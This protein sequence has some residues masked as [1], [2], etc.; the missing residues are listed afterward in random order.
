M[1]KIIFI[2]FLFFGCATQYQGRGFSG[3]FS[4]LKLNNDLYQV[5]FNGNGYTSAARVQRYFLRRCAEIAL[6]NKYDYFAIV[7]Q[8]AEASKYSTGTNEY[9][10]LSKN[11]VG[12]YT[13]KGTSSESFITK[14]GRTG[15]IK[16]FKKGSQPQ[17]AF[18][19][20]TILNGTQD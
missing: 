2:S 13:Y 4:E 20:Q 8:E 14:H 6:E 16:L 10:Q 18:D 7:D 3:G 5:T 11:Y 9:G 15:T 17:I 1:K 19:A 12:D